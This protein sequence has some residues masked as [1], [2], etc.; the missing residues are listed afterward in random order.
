LLGVP[1][2]ET[3]AGL[4]LG[5]PVEW[6]PVAAPAGEALRGERVILRPLDPAADA[7]SLHAATHEDPTIWT[8]LRIGP[9]ADA[10]ALREVLEREAG[11]EGY[12]FHA[13]EPTEAGRALGQ[14]A[15]MRIDPENGTIEIGSIFFAPGLRRTPAATEAIFLLARHVF[16]DLGYRR[17]EWKCNALNAGSRRAAERFGFRFEGVFRQDEII[18]G[19]NRDTAWFSIVDDEWPALRA[20]FEAWLAPGNFDADGA[21]IRSLGE[22]TPD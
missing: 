10:A 11:A 3:A 14:A 4:P 8:Y 2:D 7:E 20:A 15:Y 21:Q 13:V 1:A 19:R 6:S 5:A 22:L 12:A 18:K 16:D 9:F 17:L